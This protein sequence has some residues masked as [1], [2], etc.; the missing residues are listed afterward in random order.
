MIEY[1]DI[2]K[3]IRKKADLYNYINPFFDEQYRKSNNFFYIIYSLFIYKN[4]LNNIYLNV[5]SKIKLDLN[6]KIAILTQN[7][8]LLIIAGAG[9][10]KTTTVAAKIKFMVDILKIDPSEILLLSYTNEAVLE[11]KK[12]ICE[13]FNIK[14]SILTFHKFA[15]LLTANKKRIIDKIDNEHF[16]RSCKIYFKLKLNFY[17]YLFYDLEFKDLKEKTLKWQKALDDFI[18]DFLRRKYE[19]YEYI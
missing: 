1:L 13:K 5:D 7:K 9:S 16:L 10:G 12:I 2:D 19:R 15:I 18:S 17:L 8:N 14:V 4:Y 11:M 6:Q 3:F